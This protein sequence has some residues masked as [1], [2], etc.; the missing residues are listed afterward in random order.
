MWKT[1]QGGTT[2]M[3][4]RR[5]II[6][7]AGLVATVAFAV[8]MV[9]QL[10]AQKAVPATDFTHAAIAEVHDAQGQIVLKG[11]FAT[12][13]EP[14]EDDVERKAALQPAGTDADA[15]GEAEVEFVKSAP[16][17][18][19]IEFSVRN[20]AAGTSVTFLIDG[21]VVGQA[22]V[23]RRGRAELEVDVPIPGAAVSR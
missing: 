6:P 7:I 19:E 23:D 16:A 20:L 17:L 21:Q 2:N 9:M 3:G 8:Y 15:A 22:S 14:D 4:N 10:H 13:D 1:T 11:Q 5:Q 12:A 18:Q